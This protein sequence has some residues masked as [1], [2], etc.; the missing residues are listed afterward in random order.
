MKWSD[1]KLEDIERF[2]KLMHLKR[3]IVIGECKKKVK[4]NKQ[5]GKAEMGHESDNLILEECKKS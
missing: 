2:N 5:Q 4:E 1:R 3:F